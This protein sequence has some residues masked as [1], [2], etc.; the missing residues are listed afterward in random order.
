MR[1]FLV[2]LGLA[3]LLVSGPE[4]SARTFDD[5]RSLPAGVQAVSTAD[6]VRMAAG[7]D[8]TGPAAPDTLL[9]APSDSTALGGANNP[10]LLDLPP[11]RPNDPPVIMVADSLNPLLLPTQTITARRV[12]RM[13]D[14]G[15][16]RLS[17]SVVEASD[18]G[19]IADIAR[20]LPSTR[21]TVNSRGESLFMLRGAPERH[22]R[23]WLDGIPL[24]IPW[25]ER[26]DLSMVSMDAVGSVDVARGPRSVLDG[27]NALAGSIRLRTRDTDGAEHRTLFGAQGAGAGARQARAMHIRRLGG[28]SVLAS[29]AYRTR[30]AFTLPEDVALAFHQG[31]RLARTNSELEQFSGLVRARRELA[32]GGS[33][34][35]LAQV[36]DGSKGVVPEGHVEDAR[37]WRQPTL[38]RVLLGGSFDRPVSET[39]KWGAEAAFSVDFFRQDIRAFDDASY[40][41]PGLEPGADFES[42]DDRTLYGRAAVHRSVGGG[43]RVGVQTV[44][45]HTR[46]GETLEVDGPENEFVQDVGSIVAQ[47]NV[48]TGPWDMQAGAGFERADTP[49][50]GDKPA[51]DAFDA[52]VFQLGVSRIVGESMQVQASASRRSR[53]PS[54]RELFSGALGRF[55]VNDMLEPE[56]QDY[57]DVGFAFTGRRLELGSTLFG[58]WVDGGIERARLDGGQFQRQNVDVLRT[59]G[60]EVTA[61]WRLGPGWRAQIHQAFL[62]S[63]TKQ[64]GKFAG[65]AEDRP[66]Y[67]TS[68]VLTR[69]PAIGWQ[70]RLEI[71]ATGS[72]E[73]A[74]E[75][76][77]D[78][79][80]RLPSQAIWSLRLGH[81]MFFERGPFYDGELFV[82]WNNFLDQR[83]DSQTG[84]PEAGRTFW[85][86]TK[87]SLRG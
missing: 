56:R 13:V 28:W 60:A 11:I 83:L 67:L 15:R 38:R 75:N 7:V 85:I 4:V 71:T 8:S 48:A 68:V 86:G 42:D 24:T 1:I 5:R 35:W 19:S 18:A 82:R 26:A 22:V 30:D 76:A 2:A 84:L 41:T 77:A 40:L 20:L 61:L 73:S 37:F 63:R 21:L 17:E 45:R 49:N 72:R 62:H 6:S 78:G 25:D 44:W 36:S 79:F 46:H 3:C 23:V 54:L 65:P 53:F 57:V 51:R 43:Q 52:P 81:R 47:W 50:T 80:Q 66:D 64:A 33:L 39:S 70:A 59:L 58:A 27:P 31:D 34:G 87:L 32:G 12:R 55:V 10:L 9:R 74:D 16:S 29:A 69:A 14:A